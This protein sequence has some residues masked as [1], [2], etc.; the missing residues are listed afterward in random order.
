M[1]KNLVCT[2]LICATA[3]PFTLL[4]IYES[5]TFIIKKH[6][7]R[8][9]SSA[10]V[11]V[12]PEGEENKRINFSSSGNDEKG[13]VNTERSRNYI[14][15]YTQAKRTVYGPSIQIHYYADIAFIT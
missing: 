4:M 6:P 11:C 1:F 14:K 3:K 15:I 8:A 5:L 9:R 7:A 10:I 2:T 12:W 13:K